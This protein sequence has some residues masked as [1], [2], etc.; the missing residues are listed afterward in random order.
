MSNSFEKKNSKKYFKLVRDEIPRILN[1]QGIEFSCHIASEE[2]YA[3]KLK[4]KLLEEV[5][6]F[7]ENPSPEE[8]ADIFEV[9]RALSG[10][11]GVD[12]MKAY[13]ARVEKYQDRGGFT[14]RIILEEV[15]E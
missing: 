5:E 11:H 13:E 7:F 3:E 1:E 9:L 8:L 10:Y 2:E 15:L 6:E 4:E 12:I 14:G